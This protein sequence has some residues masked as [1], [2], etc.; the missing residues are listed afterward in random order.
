M[1]E[2]EA[3]VQYSGYPRDGQFARYGSYVELKALS[4]GYFELKVVSMVQLS[5]ILVNQV[6]IFE[7]G[8]VVLIAF[9]PTLGAVAVSLLA[10]NSFNKIAVG[11]GWMRWLAILPAV[12]IGM[13]AASCLF[14]GGSVIGLVVSCVVLFILVSFASRLA[15]DEIGRYGIQV[16]GIFVERGKKAFRP[17]LE[18]RLM[19]E[20]TAGLPPVPEDMFLPPKPRAMG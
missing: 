8:N 15:A 2:S 4:D 11:L 18:E 7:L 5:L 14:V 1:S 10:I 9:I 16:K 13:S 19:L 6:L 3:P 20:K 17:V 12:V